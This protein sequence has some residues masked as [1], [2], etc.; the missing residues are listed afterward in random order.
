[1]A[2][3]IGITKQS[4]W[5]EK[6]EDIFHHY[7]QDLRHAHYIRALLEKGETNILELAAGSFRDTAALNNWGYHC[8]GTDYSEKSVSL[9]KH[10]YPVFADRF[11]QM[12]AFELS[13]KDKFFDLTYHNGFWVLFND[14]K[15]II[16]LAREQARVT[17]HRMI[18]TVHNKHNQ[19]F[20]QYFNRLSN[21][22]VL[23][24]I[25]FFEVEEVENLMKQVCKKVITIPVGKGK[26]YFEDALIY[27][28]YSHP[29]ALKKIMT[30]Q[31]NDNLKMS[32]RLL[33]IGEL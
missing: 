13:F 3:A 5:D 33:C 23:Y 27:A 24:K 9:A 29:E 16:E 14:D 31:G 11:Y 10:E 17:K 4:E 19:D 12:D 20:I 2:K 22:D 25:R 32:E 6:W 8:A 26:K 21:D 1:M 28:G 30:E 15:K 18:A 7:Q